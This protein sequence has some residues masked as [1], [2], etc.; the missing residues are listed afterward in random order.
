[1]SSFFV[2]LQKID[3]KGGALSSFFLRKFTADGI[4]HLRVL[5]TVGAGPAFNFV[6]FGVALKNYVYN[7]VFKKVVR[8]TDD[9]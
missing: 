9:R 3:S 4:F 5:T 8:G 7:L 1:M 6:F 2:S